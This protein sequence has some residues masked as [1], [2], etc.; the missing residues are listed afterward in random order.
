M[1]AS[2]FA[3]EPGLAPKR[4]PHEVD[5]IIEHLIR[6]QHDDGL[7]NLRLVG[8]AEPVQRTLVL[9]EHILEEFV[10]EECGALRARKGADSCRAALWDDEARQWA[11]EISQH[12][13]V[14]E[15]VSRF[16]EIQQE[17]KSE[18]PGTRRKA[19]V[20]ESE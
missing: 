4:L 1:L 2:V 12:P 5:P 18:R 19:L 8:V 11:R 7:T 9:L 13:A 10:H 20:K 17:L 6:R 14:A 3:R 16:V 15:K